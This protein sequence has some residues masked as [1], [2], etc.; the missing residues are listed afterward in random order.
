MLACSM[1]GE[2]TV[3]GV[4]RS[5]TRVKLERYLQVGLVAGKSGAIDCIW[6]IELQS[7][8]LSLHARRGS[9]CSRSNISFVT[10]KPFLKG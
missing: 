3:K 7:V 2:D 5:S 6:L 8:S 10:L 9:A 4:T 1:V